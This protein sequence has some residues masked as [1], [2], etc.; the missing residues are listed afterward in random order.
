MQPTQPF[1]SLRIYIKDKRPK[2]FL[3]VAMRKKKLSINCY[4]K[5]PSVN[6]GR[7]FDF[8]TYSNILR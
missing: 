4:E 1:N 7:F 3:T 2:R 5:K 6:S 8:K